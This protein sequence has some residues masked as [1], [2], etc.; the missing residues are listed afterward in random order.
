[1][2]LRIGT[3]G[4]DLALWQAHH[5]AER[6]GVEV[7]TEIIVLKTRGDTID[8]IPLTEVPGKAFFTAE[9]ERALIEK[10]VDLAVHSHKDLPTESPPGLVVAAVPAR[11]PAEERLLIL[12]TGHDPN[13][14]LLP[15]RRG[16]RVGTGSPRRAEQLLAMRPD[17]RIE[18]LRGNVPTR[19]RKLREG[20]HDAIMLAA[21]GLYRLELD[22]SDLHVVTLPPN[23]FV[24]APA[25]GALAVQVR[26]DDAATLDV[27]RRLLHDEDTAGLI[28]AERVLLAR[29][30]GGCNLPLG[31]YMEF[32]PGAEAGSG[33]GRG[34]GRVI[35]VAFLGA[36]HP[37]A[38]HPA[39]W[40]RS[41][42]ATPEAA[43]DAVMDLLSARAP[44]GVGT[45]AGPL[46]GLCV[47]LV[48]T[49]DDE[50]GSGLGTRL[51][52]LGAQPRHEAVLQV[53]D[54]DVPGLP[55]RL[56][57]LR[58]G[59]AL[60]VTS[61]HAA[62]R[63]AGLSVPDGVIVAAVGPATAAALAEAGLSV[64]VVG[65]DGGRALADALELKDGAR[66]LFPCAEAAR[67]D[68]P[69]ALSAR[70]MPV[71]RLVLYRTVS[72]ARGEPVQGAAVRVYMS[73][74]AV[75]SSIELGR[76]RDAGD[77]VRVAIG[78]TTATALAEQALPAVRP[79]MPG[80]EG[81]IAALIAA[82]DPANKQVQ[83]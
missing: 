30:G 45:G 43:A 54:L 60:A 11:G 59:D 46:A 83:A 71:E 26:E 58:P 6:L 21:A 16:A 13:G 40:V 42:G 52:Q 15:L 38:G 3:R 28:D 64:D 41:E 76:E 22:T 37:E 50:Q 19:V 61:R 81:V 74:S 65:H 23:L 17:L 25:Q 31:A 78:E 4:S 72:A 8:D 68:L 24:P 10:D 77:V 70:G 82:N 67:P 27:C 32:A 48:G 51:A 69:E 36:D 79:E 1:M 20:Q 44:S 62:R 9:I 39:R 29:A 63:L 53:E 75:K 2:T 34:R 66:V 18:P 80:A 5:I 57:A 73:P 12:P 14:A 35:A 33:P 7:E 56:A 55:A 49:A 47:A